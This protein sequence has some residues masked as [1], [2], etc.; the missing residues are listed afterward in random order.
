VDFCL[1]DFRC[2]GTGFRIVAEVGVEYTDKVGI[3]VF[4]NVEKRHKVG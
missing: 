1:F 2:E 4:L 3:Y